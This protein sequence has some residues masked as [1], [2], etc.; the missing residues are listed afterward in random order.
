MSVCHW[1]ICRFQNKLLTKQKMGG[2]QNGRILRERG[3]V[4]NLGGGFS[5]IL[6]VLSKNGQKRKTRVWDRGAP[7][8]AVKHEYQHD[9]IKGIHFA[10]R[11]LRKMVLEVGC[12]LLGS[13]EE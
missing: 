1:Q 2:G 8:S 4:T 5:D 6:A 13:S 10:K 7:R 11:V 12:F 3:R 9:V